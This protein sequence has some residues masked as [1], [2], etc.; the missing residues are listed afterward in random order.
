M[1]GRNDGYTMGDLIVAPP[2]ISPFTWSARRG[3]DGVTL[4]G[5]APSAE[6]RDRVMALARRLAG[7][8][9]VSDETRLASGFP[10]ASI[11]VS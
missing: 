8:M 2:V 1:R 9:T 5:F 10:A 4:M 11:S 7:G 3:P 6:A